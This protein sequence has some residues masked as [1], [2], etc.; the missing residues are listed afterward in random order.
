[1]RSKHPDFKAIA[2]KKKYK[3]SV[4]ACGRSYKHNKDLKRHGLMHKLLVINKNVDHLKDQQIKEL[5]SE[6]Q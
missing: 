1:M 6:I 2:L 5:E 4:P 3:C